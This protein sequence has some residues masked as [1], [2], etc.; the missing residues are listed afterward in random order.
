MVGDLREWIKR[1]EDHGSL[2]RIDEEVHWD[3]ELVAIGYCDHKTVGAPALLFENITDY[4]DT[5][6][7]RVLFN[8]TSS[9]TARAALTMNEDPELSVRELISRARDRIGQKIE[10]VFVDDSSATVYENSLY[11]DDVDLYEFPAPKCWPHDGGRYI[12]TAN[13]TISRNPETGTI[14]V[15]TY[16]HMLSGKDRTT[17]HVA[18]GKDLRK[19]MKDMW[20]RDEPLEVAVAFGISPEI[21]SAS[22]SKYGE[23]EN[24]YHYAGGL[25]GEAVEI[26]EGELTGLPI[27]AH[28]EI[29]AEGRLEP[30]EY[31]EEGPFG[32]FSGY[33]GHSGSET[34]VFRIEA[35]HFRDDPILTTS[36]MAQYPGGDNG[37]SIA[38]QWPARIWNALENAGVPGIKGV[39]RSPEN[40]TM[41]VVSIEQQYPGHPEQVGALTLHVPA[42]AY[43]HK[44]TVVVDEDVDPT[45]MSQVMWALATRFNPEHDVQIM[46]DAWGYSLDPSL[47]DDMRQWGSKM[48][49]DATKNYKYYDEG[50]FPERTALR[51][52]TYESVRERW[53]EFDFEEEFPD[54][55]FFVEEER[56]SEE[57][58]T[59][60]SGQMD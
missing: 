50:E 7:Q 10:P 38:I 59:S 26:V 18:E 20:K 27:P 51:R 25:A 9:S 15:G 34:P 29:V 33:Y 1:V 60:M 49:L 58:I 17:I 54:L 30:Y 31:D 43:N 8:M 14:N 6:G 12:G 41:S 32:E 56:S 16:R 3:E 44:M 21:K 4:Q 24:E 5:Y 45:D 39:Y 42:A 23:Q 13:A 48:L 52:D 22:G 11:G 40:V 57:E 2:K 47:P 36:I 35:L 53:D 28:A 37:V 19:H 55:P 46:T